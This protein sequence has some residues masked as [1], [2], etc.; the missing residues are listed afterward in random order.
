MTSPSPSRPPKIRR[1]V[2]F[3]DGT[4]NAFSHQESN[5]WRLYQ[6]VDQTQGDQAV[7]YI[8]GVGTQS[9]KPLAAIDGA[10]G[11]GVPENV[12]KLY[13][14]IC[15]GW[16]PGTEIWMF[17]FSRGAFTI[18]T[19][20]AL[21]SHQGL[22]PRRIGG[23]PVS[24]ADMIANSEYAW[25][26]YRQKTT[27]TPFHSHP[28]IATTR[29]LLGV[30]WR[31]RK[32]HK[33]FEQARAE[34]DLPG[35]AERRRPPI[36]MLGLFDTVEA[37]GMPI[38][39][40]RPAVNRLIWPVSFRNERCSPLVRNVRHALAIDDERQ[41]FHPVRFDQQQLERGQSIQEVWFPGMHSDVGGGYP[42]DALAMIPL[43]W[44]ATEAMALGLSLKQEAHEA[45]ALR[46]SPMAA[47]H[48]S[49]E[50]VSALYRYDPRQILAGHE[51]G[52]PPVLHHSVAVRVAH[53]PSRYGPVNLPDAFTFLQAKRPGGSAA[54]IVENQRATATDGAMQKISMPDPTILEHARDIVW[55]RRLHYFVMLWTLLGLAALPWFTPLLTADNP[56]S[57]QA[58]APSIFGEALFLAR[59]AWTWLV[60]A[61]GAVT[62]GAAARWLGAMK[63]HPLVS[64]CLILLF[65]LMFARGVKLQRQIRDISRIAWLKPVNGEQPGY[66]PLPSMAFARRLRSSPTMVRFYE[67]VTDYVLPI[68]L[69]IAMI[70]AIL[71][72]GSRAAVNASTANGRICTNA[73]PPSGGAPRAARDVRGE[74]VK[75]ETSF[76]PSY[77]CW[78]SGIMLRKGVTYRIE[79]IPEV[80]FTDRTTISGLQGFLNTPGLFGPH[81]WISSRLLKRWPA[82]PWFQLIYQIGRG[83]ADIGPLRAVGGAGP[84]ADVGSLDESPGWGY[85]QSWRSLPP[86]VAQ[87]IEARLRRDAADQRPLVATVTP[88]ADGEFHMFVNDAM[89]G[90]P[91]LG[92]STWFY[93]NNAGTAAVFVAIGDRS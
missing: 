8:P 36:R 16:E 33:R 38:E 65:V 56:G 41:T 70:G 66:T 10:T 90:M 31:L 63:A 87:Q 78:A 73:N 4:G 22:M 82:E 64:L 53:D 62:P 5:V 88:A 43:H 85:G 50:G 45:W 84:A 79:I 80:A 7:Y 91:L 12:R 46:A 17:G 76:D 28:T 3:A 21:I 49:R 27:P 54:S 18:R 72:L 58:A 48:D 37:F 2:V 13:R 9:I 52:G 47:L 14:F 55:W 71:V 81:G 35:N 86:T 42:D 20:A 19:L 44:I 89:V 93:G 67:I 23:L 39:E 32:G 61:L 92:T 57:A 26:S 74:R 24:E 69:T 40:L 6:A 25:R 29:T 77:P 59:G 68:A 11:L 1:I 15:W 51:H 60:D 83:D 34:L 30:W 75:A